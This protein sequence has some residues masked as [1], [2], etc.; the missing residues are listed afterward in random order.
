MSLPRVAIWGDGRAARALLHSLD[1]HGVDVVAH[2]A[3]SA[4]RAPAPGAAPFALGLDAF[5][6]LARREHADLVVL[7]ISDDAITSTAA[8]MAA[9][10]G[11]TKNVIH[12]SGALSVDALLPLGACARGKLHP[13]ASLGGR[14][15]IPAG[16]LAAVDAT[17]NELREILEELATALGLSPFSLNPGSEVAYHVG[18]VFVA[19][20][21]VALLDVGIEAFV[22]A[23]A[24]P[25]QA[26]GGALA[27]LRSV[28]DNVEEA[29]ALVAA[30]TGPLARGDAGVV[31]RHL[32]ELERRGRKN[33]GELYRAL[34]R[35]LLELVRPGHAG[36]AEI[37]RLL[38]DGD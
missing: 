14:G 25:E 1:A 35:R 30:L 20:L 29:P 5:L 22:R 2:G 36:H 13:L 11:V 38:D 31:A 16:S 21:S 24:N 3:R 26:R 10:E 12:L 33:E 27:L 4:P 6:D 15:P 18:A 19:N 37:E 8:E 9:R 17:S 34:S 32:E 23:G 7:A 28:L